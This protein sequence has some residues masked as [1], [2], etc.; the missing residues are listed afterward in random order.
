MTL[1]YGTGYT[2]YIQSI[3]DSSGRTVTYTYVVGGTL[4]S[5]GRAV[6]VLT[7]VTAPATAAF[8]LGTTTTYNWDWDFRIT[9]EVDGKG[10]TIVSNTYLPTADWGQ[11]LL[12]SQTVNGHTCTVY[13]T[14]Y[15]TPGHRLSI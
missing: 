9:S 15:N 3:S 1:D 7:K 6:V 14:G 11:H 5:N 13:Y 12:A 10:N 4:R 2:P 8:P